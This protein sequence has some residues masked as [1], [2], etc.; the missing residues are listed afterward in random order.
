MSAASYRHCFRFVTCRFSSFGSASYIELGASADYSLINN[1]LVLYERSCAALYV[2]VVSAWE[3][4]VPL[5][6]FYLLL[7]LNNPGLLR[8]LM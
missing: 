8:V 7:L 1:P 3:L 2:K 6:L 5:F 4:L